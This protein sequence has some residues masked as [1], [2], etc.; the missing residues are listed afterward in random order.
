MFVVKNTVKN[1]VQ[2]GLKKSGKK[3]STNP[4]KSLIKSLGVRLQIIKK[5]QLYTQKSLKM[6]TEEILKEGSNEGKL[7]QKYG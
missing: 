7:Q 4:I 2:N 3:S 1:Q 6:K 5:C